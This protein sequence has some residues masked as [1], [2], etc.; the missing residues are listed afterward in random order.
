MKSLLTVGLVAYLL[1]CAVLYFSQDRLLF[2]RAWAAEE[3]QANLREMPGVEELRLQLPEGPTLHGWLRPGTKP[4]HG[5]LL[6]FGGNAQEISRWMVYASKRYR[7]WSVVSFNYR[8]FGHSEGTPGEAAF[9]A[10]TLRIYDTL[11]TRTDIRTGPVVLMGLSMGTSVAVQLAAQRPVDG[12][13]LISPFDSIRTI[14]KERYPFAPVDWLLRHPFDSLVHAPGMRAPV[15]MLA[16]EQDRIVAPELTQRLYDAWGGP[17]QLLVDATG[18]HHN[19]LFRES[20]QQA[21]I[22]FL[23]RS[24]AQG[25]LSSRSSSRDRSRELTPSRSRELPAT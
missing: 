11:M 13:I 9:V 3:A 12:M 5:L 21:I 7:R 20:S 22:E 18:T 6:Y 25:V 8:G 14:A 2:F 24:A 19:L 16:G 15:L 4:E 17:R 23:A 1:L 10:D